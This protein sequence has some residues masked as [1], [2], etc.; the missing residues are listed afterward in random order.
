MFFGL[1]RPYK[2]LEDLI[3]AFDALSATEAESFTLTVVGETWEG[4]ELPAELIAASPYRDRI[5]FVNRYV[6]DSEAAA[7]L[8]RS[9]R[10]RPCPTGAARPAGRC[11]SR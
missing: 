6:T 9:R 5:N 2:G 1:I 10:H 11:R 4:W 8:R 7:F 3:K